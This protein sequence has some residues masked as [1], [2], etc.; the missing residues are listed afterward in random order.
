MHLSLARFRN[1]LKSPSPRRTRLQRRLLQIEPLDARI[2]PA[3]TVV[4][5][6]SVL[7]IISDAGS[8]VASVRFLGLTNI[9]TAVVAVFNNSTGTGAPIAAPVLTSP[10][11]T[12]PILSVAAISFVGGAG[13]DSFVNFT[14]IRS[15]FDGGSGTN[16]FTGGT[17]TDTVVAS[18]DANFT[19]Y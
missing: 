7:S 3:L 15:S 10:T 19:L 18:G 12:I 17:G 16:S 8:D 1:G 4:P 14:S 6:G 2:A 5:S 13:N 9:S 11:S